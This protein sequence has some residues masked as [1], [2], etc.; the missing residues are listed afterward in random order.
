M[1]IGMNPKFRFLTLCFLLLF[2]ATGYAKLYRGAE[3]RTFDSYLYGRFEVRM[4]SAAGHG[5][6]SSF[7]TF[8]DYHAQGLSGTQH[9]N[10]IDLE[11]MGK[12]NNKV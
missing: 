11:W 9:W 2:T 12:L 8:R 1:P 7:F 3:F 10:E 6:V 5:V 4:K